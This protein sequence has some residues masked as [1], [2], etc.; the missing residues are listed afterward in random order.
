MSPADTAL[1]DGSAM[2]RSAVQRGFE[3]GRGLEPA[4]EAGAGEQPER[5]RARPDA[6]VAAETM[7]LAAPVNATPI[8]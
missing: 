2:R 3:R 4:G 1:L 7:L 5:G 6:A 8:G